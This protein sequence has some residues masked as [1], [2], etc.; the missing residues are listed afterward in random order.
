MKRIRLEGTPLFD[1]FTGYVQ[2]QNMPS[3]SEMGPHHP[4]SPPQAS[5]SLPPGTKGG[6]HTRMWVGGGGGG[7]PIRTTRE[8]A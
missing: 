3:K 4:L 1:T 8:K 6:D 5:V 7:V 2:P